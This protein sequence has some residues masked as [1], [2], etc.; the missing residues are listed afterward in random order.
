MIRVDGRV[1]FD[2]IG[3]SHYLLCRFL[4][5]RLFRASEFDRISAKTMLFSL[6]NPSLR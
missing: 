2:L 3:D 6:E 5:I 1:C 4:R